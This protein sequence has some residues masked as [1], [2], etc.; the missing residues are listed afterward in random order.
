MV[1]IPPYA[2]LKLLLVLV[3]YKLYTTFSRA[4]HRDGTFYYAM[5]GC[6][7][8]DYHLQDGTIALLA[9]DHLQP[10]CQEYKKALEDLLLL[11]LTPKTTIEVNVMSALW[12]KVLVPIDQRNQVIQARE[13]TID[14]EVSNLRSL[15]DELKELRSQWPMILNESKLVANSPNILAEFPK[16][17]R[18]GEMSEKV[19]MKL[20][21]SKAAKRGHSSVMYFIQFL[22][23]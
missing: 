1:P 17:A 22:I 18:A 12:S 6:H 23:R 8:M 2:V 7:Y 5:L 10:I 9:S 19:E 14:V 20:M 4:V 3:W 15:I 16:S 11:Y 21:K 13:A